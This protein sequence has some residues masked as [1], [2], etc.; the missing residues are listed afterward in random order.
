MPHP[1]M[2]CSGAAFTQR[3]GRR[4]FRCQL[5]DEQELKG[6][7]YLSNDVLDKDTFRMLCGLWA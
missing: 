1:D 7:I 6:M 2:K 4:I 3:M 5:V